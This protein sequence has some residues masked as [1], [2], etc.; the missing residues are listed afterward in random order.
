MKALLISDFSSSK[1]FYS[2]TRLEN[3][4]KQYAKLE[5]IYL[6][7][8]EDFS[9]FIFNKNNDYYDLVIISLTR[10]LLNY[11]LTSEIFSNLCENDKI[12]H[13]FIF[14]SKNLWEKY[15]N[16]TKDKVTYFIRR[17]VS[18]TSKEFSE[19]IISYLS[20]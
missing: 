20:S 2:I 5:K 9:K 8:K 1:S 19:A 10:Q 11:L 17:G 13:V 12:K 4:I 7:K 14:G 3:N 6:E 15:T 18:K 16:F